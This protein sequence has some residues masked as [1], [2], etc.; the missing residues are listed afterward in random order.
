MDIRKAIDEGR[1]AE[2]AAHLRP[3]SDQGSSDSSNDLAIVYR[4]MGQPANELFF[5]HRAFEQNRMSSSAL[6]TLLR[7]LLVQGF[8]QSAARIYREVRGERCIN[9]SH[10]VN[11]AIALIR[12]NRVEE[13]A[14]ALDR[15]DGFP[16]VGAEDLKVEL[17][18]ARARFE[19]DRAFALL[20]RLTALGED[21]ET[22]K[23]SQL[24]ASGDMA[25]VVAHFD[26]R[27]PHHA[28]VRSQGKTALQAAIA[29]ADRDRVQRY[30]SEIE[31]IAGSTVALA[32][33]LLEGRERVEVRGAERTWR[34]PFVATNFSVA[35]PQVAGVFY[36][37]AALDA[38]RGLIRPGQ[39]VVDVGANIGNHTV[40]FAGEAGCRVVP[41]ECNPRMVENLKAT[42]ALNQ[43]EGRS[44]CRIWARRCRPSWGPFRSS[45]SGTT[46]PS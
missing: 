18:M 26:A 21:M 27:A 38:L 25:G 24:F 29:L 33:G 41:F 14:E 31:G 45:S 7:A 46:I 9:R 34:F 20:D 15:T 4:R 28:G 32:R 11:G 35:L 5:A 6:Q 30:L 17:L 43:L 12:I 19:H 40:Y 22:Q 1:Y 44:I 16:S 42:I 23:T 3:L 39:T 2:A 10:H 8:F 13:A 37:V 36:E